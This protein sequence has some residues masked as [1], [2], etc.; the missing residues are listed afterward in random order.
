MPLFWEQPG[1]EPYRLV[2]VAAGGGL[3]LPPS[4]VHTLGWENRL[5]A[6]AGWTGPENLTLR[7][8]A[9][10]ALSPPL[11]ARVMTTTAAAVQFSMP[12]AGRMQ[13]MGTVRQSSLAVVPLRLVLNGEP[14]GQVEFAASPGRGDFELGL[15]CPAG[16]NRLE[17]RREAGSGEEIVFTRLI[18]NR[19]PAGPAQ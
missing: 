13:L 14:A 15:S 6:F 11:I 9:P 16:P 3:Y 19:R 8:E 2:G 7:I 4:R 12:A 17:F 18:I 10:T 1:R 5:P